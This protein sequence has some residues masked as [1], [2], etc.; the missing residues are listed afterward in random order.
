MDKIEAGTNSAT[1]ATQPKQNIRRPTIIIEP[2]SLRSTLRLKELWLYR[3]L[4]LIL[5]QRDVKLRYKQTALGVAWVV[6]QPLTAAAVFAIIF[7]RFAR[8]PSE[9]APYLLF[10]LCGLLPWSYFAGALQRAGSS[11]VAD[12]KL[13]S[14]VYFPRLVIPVASILAVLLD[15]VVM[16]T[17]LAILLVAYRVMPTWRVVTLPFFLLLTT[18][19]AIG[20]SL[21]LAALNVQYRDFMYAMPF[22][23]QVW[24]Y[25]SPV[26][27]ATSLIPDHWRFIY[28]LNP[29]VGCIEGFRWALL[30]GSSLSLSMLVATAS[31]TLVALCSGVV[32]FRRVE[33]TFSDII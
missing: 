5:A 32:F 2:S 21:W 26:V 8:L 19:L 31:F 3:D 1:P 27:Y 18:L 20:V 17:V 11:L 15:F 30:R 25:A 10:V 24:L 33:R 16:L 22:L 23:I 29:M 14:K 6:L 7:G 13:V 4:L 9:G 12:A 28:S